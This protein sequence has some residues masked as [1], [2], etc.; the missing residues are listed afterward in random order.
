MTKM[1]VDCN[2]K[3]LANIF[4]FFLYILEKSLKVDYGMFFLREKTI[5][6]F[7][8]D[9]VRAISCYKTGSL[10]IFEQFWPKYNK[11]IVT[12]PL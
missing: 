4:K 12:V 3:K 1:E 6:I 9:V 11:I 5:N 2:L 10:Q 8:P 7:L